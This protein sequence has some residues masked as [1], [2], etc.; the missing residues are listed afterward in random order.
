MIDLAYFSF[1]LCNSG[2]II[3][4]QFSISNHMGHVEVN[5]FIMVY[6]ESFF[7]MTSSVVPSAIVLLLEKLSIQ[8]LFCRF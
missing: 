7:L 8:Y 1:T 6:P 2:I 3:Y 5:V 4:R